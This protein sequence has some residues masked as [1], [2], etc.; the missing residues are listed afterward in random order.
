MTTTREDQLISMLVDNIKE[1]ITE[2][3]YEKS[4]IISICE[5]VIEEG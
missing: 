5:Q 1:L 4:H 2:C 3:G